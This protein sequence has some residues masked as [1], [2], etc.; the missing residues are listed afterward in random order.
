MNHLAGRLLYLVATLDKFLQ[1]FQKQIVDTLDADIHIILKNNTLQELINFVYPELPTQSQD[2]TYLIERG[3]LASWNNEVDT[4]NTEV[5]VQFSGEETIYYSADA[6]DQ[7][8]ET[9]N[10]IQESLY[11]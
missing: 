2:A 3:I 10:P 4:L 5:L 1:L 7:N 9:Y 11:P 8:T 6:L